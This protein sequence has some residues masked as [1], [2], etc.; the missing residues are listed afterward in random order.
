[1]NMILVSEDALDSIKRMAQE[2]AKDAARLRMLF[3]RLEDDGHA[4]W[5]PEFCAKE[6]GPGPR[7]EPTMDEF[8][9]R[10][11]AMQAKP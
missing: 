5:L 7:V 10:I 9:A 6:Y 2:D 4:Y 1:M 11:D 8:R 3:E